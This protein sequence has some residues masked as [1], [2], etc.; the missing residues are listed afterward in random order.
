MFKRLREVEQELPD[1]LEKEIWNGLYIDYHPPIVE[2]VW[3]QVGENRI[4]LHR[5]HPCS[6]GEALFHP[7]PWPSAMRILSG[8]YEMGIGYGEGTEPPEIAAI[9]KLDGIR[10]LLQG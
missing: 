6:E 3:T 1:L 2:R 9:V 7:H 8:E 10:K 5:I 4:Y